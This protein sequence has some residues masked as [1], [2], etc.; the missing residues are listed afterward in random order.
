MRVAP[1][2]SIDIVRRAR[3]LVQRHVHLLII[4]LV[5]RVPGTPLLHV[6]RRVAG[7][8]CVVGESTPEL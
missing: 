3:R 1:H 4:L 7:N 5:A 6:R 2:G 8:V